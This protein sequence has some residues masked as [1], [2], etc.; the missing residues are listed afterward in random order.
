M[1]V[2]GGFERSWGGVTGAGFDLAV[3]AP[4][5]EPVDVGEGGEVDVGEAV[6][7]GLFVDAFPFV[8]PVEALDEGFILTVAL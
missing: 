8:E 7:G 1:T 2:I 6:P 3:E 4:V 5:V